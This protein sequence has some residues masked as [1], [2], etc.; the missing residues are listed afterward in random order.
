MKKKLLGLFAAFLL[1]VA[2]PLIATADIIYNS[3]TGHSYQLVQAYENGTPDIRTW[4]IANTNAKA[5]GDGWNLVT[6][7]DLTENAWL[8]TQFS[9]I[10]KAAWIG[11]TRTT[12]STNPIEGW[13]W[14]SGQAFTYTSDNQPP[15]VSGQPSG[16]WG[17]YDELNGVIYL[18]MYLA[19]QW[20]DRSVANDQ[21]GNNAY[22]FGIAEYTPVPIPAAIWLF[23]TGLVGLVGIRRRFTEKL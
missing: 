18:N 3:T 15:W 4:D 22:K 20:N 2:M 21:E 19:G 7:N 9:T 13:S 1:I 12:A 6:I 5:L 11:L 17:G 8:T 14:V 16:T 23:G 10:D